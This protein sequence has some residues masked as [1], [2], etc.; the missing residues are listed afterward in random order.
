MNVLITSVARKVWLV[1]AFR[2]AAAPFGGLVLA[3]DSDPLAVGLRLADAAVDLPRLDSPLFESA[4]LQSC[5]TQGIRLIVPTRDGELGWFAARRE[6]LA[7]AGVTVM[8]AAPDVIDLCQ[9][10][11]AFS[12]RCL[13]AGFAVADVVRHPSQARFPLFARPRRGAGGLGVARIEDVEALSRLTPWEDFIVQRFEDAPEHTIDL[14]ADLSGRVLS[15]VPR[16]RLRVAAGESVVG[17]TVEAPILIS[18]A[19]ALAESLGMIGHNT[20]QCFWDGGEPLWIEAN[21]RFGGGAALGFAAGA[22][23]PGLLM[24]LLAGEPVQPSIGDYERG[25]YLFRYST[26]YFTREA[27]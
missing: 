12:D 22:D 9:D 11:R 19:A 24:R 21:P 18:R 26:D 27:T 8:V 10:K 2:R 15:I 20:L 25:L 3:S 6:R 13:T 4:L 1:E 7:S 17:V 5:E 14:F 23:T 16:Q